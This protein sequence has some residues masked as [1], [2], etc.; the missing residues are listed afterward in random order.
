LATGD[1]DGTLF[2][3]LPSPAADDD[4][5]EARR[6]VIVEALLLLLLMHHPTFD[7]VCVVTVVVAVVVDRGVTATPVFPP[8]PT[9][10]VVA[11]PLTIVVTVFKIARRRTHIVAA[12]WAVDAADDRFFIFFLKKEQPFH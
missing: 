1:A 12:V 7:V 4:N 11:K 8:D 2:R 5:D 6:S 9:A 10:V 3:L